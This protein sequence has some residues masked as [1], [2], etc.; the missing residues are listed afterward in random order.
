MQ[1]FQW[2]LLLLE[3]KKVF[4]LYSKTLATQ[5]QPSNIFNGLSKFPLFRLI[6]FNSSGMMKQ[7]EKDFKTAKITISIINKT[8][9]FSTTN[10][11]GQGGIQKKPEQRQEEKLP[12]K[13]VEL[14]IEQLSTMV[15]SEE[16]RRK[17]KN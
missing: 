16:V 4:N 15:Q 9:M 14:S 1:V 13:L 12:E 5:R 10:Y 3:D 2:N 17:E 7:C 11:N 8:E 6:A